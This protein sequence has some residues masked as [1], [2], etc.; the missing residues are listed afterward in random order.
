MLPRPWWPAGAGTD[1]VEAD[2]V[3]G[4]DERRT[5]ASRRKVTMKARPS[6]GVPRC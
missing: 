2:T 6:R 4:D 1:G 5:F 3:V